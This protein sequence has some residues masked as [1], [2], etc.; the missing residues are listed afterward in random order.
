LPEGSPSEELVERDAVMLML[1]L[2]LEE[3]AVLVATSRLYWLDKL[4]IGINDTL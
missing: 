3:I 2:M 1:M 4:P